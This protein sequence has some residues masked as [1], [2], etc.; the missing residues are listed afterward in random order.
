M[1]ILTMTTEEKH[2]KNV[3][4]ITLG[5]KLRALREDRGLTLRELGEQSGLSLTYLSEI[6]RGTVYPSLDTLK[7]LASFFNVPVSIFVNNQSS[8]NLPVKLQY[9]RKLKNI[10]QKQLALMAGVSPGLVAQLE[11]GK[12]NASL[13]T[14]TK[15]AEALGVSVCYLILDQQDIDGLIA[16]VGPDLRF[17]LQDPK[18]QAL[19]GYICTLN[20]D[21][22]R[23]V[24]N[25]VN[26]VKNPIL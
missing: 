19:V 23:L 7:Q 12:V 17:L 3:A 10:S 13:K 18:V 2:L 24:F 16:G 25:F 11:L 21:Q 8:G 22:L 20:D 14:V 4:S 1:V 5:D 6:E 15:L 9:M 26:M